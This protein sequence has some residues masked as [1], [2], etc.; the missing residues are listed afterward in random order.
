MCIK[1]DSVTVVPAC[2]S[3]FQRIIVKTREPD[4]LPRE[5][6]T[7][8]SDARSLQGCCPTFVD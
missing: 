7:V 6:K 2:R 8:T 5:P 4:S 3:Y 1:D